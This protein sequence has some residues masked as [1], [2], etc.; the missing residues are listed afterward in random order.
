MALLVS[1][2]P[3][4]KHA[5]SHMGLGAG[6]CPHKLICSLPYS[7]PLKNLTQSDHLSGKPG[8]PGNVTEFE[9]CQG[10]VRDNVNSQV[11]VREESGKNYCQGKLAWGVK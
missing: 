1:A 11:I 3:L 10:N 9:T 2:V 7:T 8:K 4:C 6:S 5:R